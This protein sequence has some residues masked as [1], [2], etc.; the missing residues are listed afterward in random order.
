MRGGIDRHDH[1]PVPTGPSLVTSS[2]NPQD[3]AGSA[4]QPGV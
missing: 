4:C 1:S 2:T 3:Q